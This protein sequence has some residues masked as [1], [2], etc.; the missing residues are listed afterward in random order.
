MTKPLKNGVPPTNVTYSCTAPPCPYS[1]R[2]GDAAQAWHDGAY[3]SEAVMVE[4]KTVCRQSSLSHRHARPITPVIPSRAR[5][6]LRFSRS[7][8]LFL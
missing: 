7:L 5:S 4:T 3:L 8:L 2:R 1:S 6:W